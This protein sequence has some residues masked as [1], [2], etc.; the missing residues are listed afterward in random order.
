MAIS[1]P[2]SHSLVPADFGDGTAAVICRPDTVAS[3]HDPCG[4]VIHRV[5]MLDTAVGILH[6]Y[7]G[8]IFAVSP[9]IISSVKGNTTWTAPNLELAEKVA[10]AGPQFSHRAVIKVTEPDISA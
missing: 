10:V 1:E 7:N 8:V 4:E 6:L 2:A 3:K 9:P 5:A